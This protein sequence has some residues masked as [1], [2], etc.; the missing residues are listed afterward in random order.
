MNIKQT[1]FGQ[2][3]FSTEE[4]EAIQDC[5]R[6]RLGPK[7]ISQR[8]GAGGLKLAY[9]EGWKLINIAN[10]TFGFNGWS[11]SVTNQTVD[12]VDHIN[13]R[14]YVGVSAM[15]R[16]Q[17]KDGVYHED[18][19]YGVSEGL[20]S[21]ALSIEKA[22]KEAATDGLKRSLKNFGNAMGNCLGDKEYLKCVGRAPK[23][24][25]EVCNLADLKSEM[26][27]P[28]ILHARQKNK[29]NP[30]IAITQHNMMNGDQVDS[31]Y[32]KDSTSTNQ[33]KPRNSISPRVDVTTSEETNGRVKA[34]CVESTV[35]MSRRSSS[36]TGIIRAINPAPKVNPTSYNQGFTNDSNRD[37]ACPVGSPILSEEEKKKQERIRRQREKQL[38]Y[39]EQIRQNTAL[40]DSNLEPTRMGLPMATSTPFV[41]GSRNS[42]AI[43]LR[44]PSNQNTPKQEDGA[45]YIQLKN[46]QPPIQQLVAED[47]FEDEIWSQADYLLEENLVEDNENRQPGLKTRSKQR[48]RGPITTGPNTDVIVKK[49]KLSA[50]GHR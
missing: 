6:Q 21:K 11:H 12:F 16:V 49:R 26:L 47:N 29:Y 5:L 7:F 35:I 30:S 40:Q 13:G 34:L 19:G 31:K 41:G 50:S 44:L 18:I 39:Q 28:K 20:K 27:N 45:S 42:P 1:C 24:P 4:H 46:D 25:P 9:I 10:E 8:I 48:N 3:G 15:V 37:Q 38:R 23:P 32:D 17:L 43:P 14:Y 33:I 2:T 36:E 22:R